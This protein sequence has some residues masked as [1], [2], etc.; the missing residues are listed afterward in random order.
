MKRLQR[1]SCMIA[2]ALGTAA[3]TTTV[4]AQS[5][6]RFSH[7]VPTTHRSIAGVQM[8]ADSLA[9][10]TGGK[11]TVRV[12]PSEQLGKAKDHYDM[13]RDGIADAGWVVPGYTPGRFPAVA[14]LELP[15]IASNANAG[16][17][18]F[19]QWYRP[20]AAREM[21]EVHYCLGFLQ[22]PG[23]LHTSKKVEGPQD[24][25]GLKLR[26]PTAPLSEFFQSIGASSVAIPAP[27][28]REAIER[29]TIDGAGFGWQTA[30]SL[31]IS[32]AAKYHLDAPFY[33]VPVV[34]LINNA[35]YA[36]Q[37]AET[38]RAID[39]HCDGTWAQKVGADWAAWE[40]A[41]RAATAGEAGH[42]LTPLSP[43]QLQAWRQAAAPLTANWQSA[44]AKKGLDASVLLKDL[45]D[46][47]ARAGAG[48]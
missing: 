8:W 37:T 14:L 41:G 28:V 27:Q 48:Y 39:A 31:G 6:M 33:T 25:K 16:S 2:A 9:K 42:V 45:R 46:S 4:H 7:F 1:M 11:L 21:P 24:L 13:V 10:A 35:F 5:E 19:D 32:K 44:V 15:F 23:V 20:L 30:V 36:R 17:L 47:L 3:V 29:G 43:P 26:S 34:Y 22:D 40:A 18:A 12:F 38:R